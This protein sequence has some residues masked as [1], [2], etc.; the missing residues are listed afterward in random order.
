MNNTAKHVVETKPLKSA[1][2]FDDFKALPQYEHK[3]N[4]DYELHPYEECKNRID[5]VKLM[6]LED[7][8]DES[9]EL[10]LKDVD[11]KQRV[12]ELLGYSGISVV[13]LQKPYFAWDLYDNPYYIFLMGWNYRIG[14]ETHI[15]GLRKGRY[16]A[17]AFTRGKNAIISKLLIYRSELKARGYQVQSD[18]ALD[19]TVRQAAE[20]KR[21]EKI[22]N[23]PS[24]IEA[25]ERTTPGKVF[26]QE[27][28][29]P[30]QYKI[31]LGPSGTATRAAPSYEAFNFI[32]GQPEAN[33]VQHYYSLHRREFR[34][35]PWATK[36]TPDPV[37]APTTDLTPLF[38]GQ[39]VF[40]QYHGRWTDWPRWL[41]HIVVPNYAVTAGKFGE[42]IPF[43]DYHRAHNKCYG[44]GSKH[45]TL[46]K[47]HFD[48][49]IAGAAIPLRPIPPNY[50]KIEVEYKPN[51]VWVEDLPVIEEIPEEPVEEK[52]LTEE[53]LLA[54]L[55]DQD[56]L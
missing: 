6:R 22:A 4:P 43:L 13:E 44:N 32:A 10:T 30:P 34:F 9:G 53:E 54:M 47:A 28:L 56:E 8:M 45:Y 23:V 14:G 27:G 49:F 52:E 37:L 21:Q 12:S 39:L 55:E 1:E 25:A 17:E 46:T 35:V 38:Y 40:D 24:Y 7:Y 16:S 18:M 15:I 36:V 31:I 48:K 2:H 50:H 42:G 41:K 5:T 33:G 51:P 19:P 11:C 3:F 26:W 20:L 29:E